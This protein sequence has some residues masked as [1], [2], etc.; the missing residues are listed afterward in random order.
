MYVIYIFCFLV[1]SMADYGDLLTINFTIFIYVAVSTVGSFLIHAILCKLFKIDTD[2]FIVTSVSAICSPP[3]VPV[4]ASSLK[5][6][7]VMISGIS[8][9]IIGYA[10]GNYIGI[11]VALFL[12]NFY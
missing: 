3:F 2:T 4:V 8:T 10:A 1:A 5:N 12:K 6:K 9:G 11:A 7:N